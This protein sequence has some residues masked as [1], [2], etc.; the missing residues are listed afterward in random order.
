MERARK[1]VMATL[2]SSVYLLCISYAL[3]LVVCDDGAEEAAAPGEMSASARAAFAQY[4]NVPMP[5]P[6][7]SEAQVDQI[8]DYIAHRSAPP[9]AAVADEVPIEHAAA[10]VDSPEQMSP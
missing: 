3:T 8:L 9:V 1:I 5:P 4:R 6:N 2:V 10:A 7:L